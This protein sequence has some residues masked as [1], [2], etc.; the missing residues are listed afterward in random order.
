MEGQL[1]TKPV[2]VGFDRSDSSCRALRWALDEGRFRALPVHVVHRP[3]I[4]SESGQLSDEQRSV[5]RKEVDEAIA[6]A[7]GLAAQVSIVDK[8]I[9][10]C[11]C[12]LS[13]DAAMIVLGARGLSGSSLLSLG[14]VALSVA[15][16]ARCPVV[17][18]RGHE[19]PDAGQLPV[20]VGVDE[21]AHAS[22][23]LEFAFTE[24]GAR[25]C[26]VEAIRAWHL[27][28]AVHN[29][30]ELQTAEDNLL[31]E[32][33]A[34]H[35]KR[36]PGIQATSW[37]AAGGAAPALINASKQAQLVVVGSCGINAFNEL[38]LGSVSRELL[39]HSE[40]PVAIIR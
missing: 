25:G 28:F 23:A 32:F 30:D 18:V 9:V 33:V 24:A 1:S 6:A 16:H 26:P 19:H 35:Q 15:A 36:H 5:A 10:G 8:P 39:H 40:C 17:V 7:G 21:S 38:A 20:V 14:S 4:P 3:V 12:T 27:G 34:A 2:I 37:L 11:L 22:L 13:D 29:P 31:R